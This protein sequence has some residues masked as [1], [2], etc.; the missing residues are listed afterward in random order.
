V[1]ALLV[2]GAAALAEGAWPAAADIYQ[3]ALAGGADDRQ[4]V[5]AIAGLL[6]AAEASGDPEAAAAAV[7]QAEGIDDPLVRAAAAVL[8]RSLGRRARGA[9]HGA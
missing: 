8:A 3:Q 4:R 5:E 9:D 1:R 6:R 7:A 2:T